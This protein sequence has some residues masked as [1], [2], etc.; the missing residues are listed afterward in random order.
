MTLKKKLSIIAGA[1]ITVA[2]VCVII[3]HDTGATNVVAISPA[4]KKAELQEQLA[5]ALQKYYMG[6]GN[7]Q[8]CQKLIEEI[9]QY[10]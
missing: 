1:I 4:E 3:F 5:D 2:L 6:I 8:E 9:Q 10:Q 7:Y